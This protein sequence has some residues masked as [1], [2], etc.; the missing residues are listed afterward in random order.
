VSRD[1]SVGI[2]TGYR[3]VG[4]V[5]NTSSCRVRNELRTGTIL[6]YHTGAITELYI[7]GALSRETTKRRVA[8]EWKRFR[9][10]AVAA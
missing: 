5:S 4:P 8:D 1:S 7:Y 6:P 3:L 10:D 2:A 9:K